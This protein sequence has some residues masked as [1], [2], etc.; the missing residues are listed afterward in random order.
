MFPPTPGQAFEQAFLVVLGL[1]A[2]DEPGARVGQALVIQVDRVLG[3]EHEPQAEGP[4]LLE[5][6]Q[7]GALGGRLATGGK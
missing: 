5:Q 4:G 1:Q 2:P 7:Q 6:S 3:R